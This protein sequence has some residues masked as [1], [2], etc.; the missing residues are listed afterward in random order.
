MRLKLVYGGT[1]DPPHNGH[2][3]V[4]AAAAA[5]LVASAASPRAALLAPAS[6]SP[7]A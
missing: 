4:A 6:T 5:A 1:F 2:L 7:R 3:A